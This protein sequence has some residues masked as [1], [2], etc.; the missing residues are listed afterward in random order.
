[1]NAAS[2]I[3]STGSSVDPELVGIATLCAGAV[4]YM[5]ERGLRYIYMER[6]RFLVRGEQKQMDAILCLNF[7]NTSY[8]TKLYLPANLGLGLNWNE[9][10]YILA[11]PWHSWS[12]SGIAANQPPLAILASHLGAFR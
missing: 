1:M 7:P 2:P 8:P 5:T 6:L 4:Q 9:S 10:A 12:W 3:P 11:R